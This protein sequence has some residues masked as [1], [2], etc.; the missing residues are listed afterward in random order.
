MMVLA[1][2]QIALGTHSRAPDLV[3]G[4]GVRAR[5]GVGCQVR[6]GKDDVLSQPPKQGRRRRHGLGPIGTP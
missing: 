3:Q 2:P 6:N 1:T 4:G 5:I